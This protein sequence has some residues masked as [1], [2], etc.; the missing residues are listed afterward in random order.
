MSRRPA[1]ASLLDAWKHGRL[2]TMALP[3]TRSTIKKL[4]ALSRNL[5]AYPG[6][7]KRLS[8]PAWSEV[9]A[10]IAHICGE[11]PGAAQYDDLMS[12][13]ELRGF[14]N[15][16]QWFGSSAGTSGGPDWAGTDYASDQ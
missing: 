4:C 7:D 14:D 10:E 13:D 12:E 3:P 8:E 1:R 11:R 15:L 5:C 2:A 9:A 16:L 6:C